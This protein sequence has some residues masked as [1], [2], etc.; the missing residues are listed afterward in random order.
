MKEIKIGL[1]GW[2]TVGAGVTRILQKNSALISRRLGARL[3]LVRVADL[4]LK[5]DRGMKLAPG[6]LT[7]DAAR[8]IEDPEIDIVVELIGGLD[9]AEGMVISSLRG[10]KRVV[11]ANKALL[12]ERGKTLFREAGQVRRRIFFE[13]SVGGG[14]PI[15]KIIREGLSANRISSILG[16]INGTTNYILTRMSEEGITL[17]AAVR[18][19]KKAGY[20]EKNPALDLEGIDSAHKLALLSSLAFGGWADFS[21]IYREGI[22][23]ITDEDIAYTAGLGY[24]IKLLAVA[25]QSPSGADLRVHPTLVPRRHLLSAVNGIFN[26]VYLEG[27]FS[28]SQI[29]QGEGAGQGPTASAVVAD[30]MEAGREILSGNDS[31]PPFIATDRDLKLA[32]IGEVVCR[33]YLR[34]PVIDRP[35]VL[36]RIAS[37]LG[38]GGI[39]IDSVIQRQRYKRGLVPVILMTN[40]AR[41][42]ALQTALDKISHLE[43][44][45]GTPVRIRVED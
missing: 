27:D 31:T 37:I 13:A 42:K 8:I 16:I 23:E 41:E 26:A 4:N 24:T 5:R 19:A 22:N 32:P 21:R 9:P 7:R 43:V 20:A 36:A 2:G 38:A 15:I 40:Q 35:G 34:I 28:K 6:I 30:L 17:A 25:K 29:F 18:G 39:S 33:H 10:G 45:R 44:V 1:I 3:R 11:T 12:A 14:I